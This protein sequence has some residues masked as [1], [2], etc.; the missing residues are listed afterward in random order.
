MVRIITDSAADFEPQ[1]L[2]KYN[3][4]IKVPRAYEE[5][6]NDVENNLL[7]LYNNGVTINAID[8]KENFWSSGDIE[9][10]MDE[11]IRVISTAN[12]DSSLKNPKIETVKNSEDKL[13]RVELEL[14]NPEGSSKTVTILTSRNIGNLVIEFTGTVENINKNMNDID[15]IIGTIKIKDNKKTPDL[16]EFWLVLGK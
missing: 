3:I 13:G 6:E 8:L 2:E 12:Y 1:E 4:T 10:R 11:Y 9:A 14:E 16:N 5:I 7:R 15:K